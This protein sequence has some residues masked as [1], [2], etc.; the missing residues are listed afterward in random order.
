MTATRDTLFDGGGVM[1]GRMAALDWTATAMGPPAR[2]PQG[3]RALVRVMLGSRYAMWMGWGAEQTF[4]FNDAY[5]PT[6]G[7]KGDWAL[8]ARTRDVWKEIWSDIGPRIESVLATSRATWDEGLLLFLERSG[9][10]EETY[11]TFSYSPL[12]DDAGQVSGIFCVVTEETDRVIGERRLAILRDLAARLARA[13]TEAD[14]FAAAGDCLRNESRDLPFV[15]AYLFDGG[16]GVGRLVARCGISPDHPAAPATLGSAAPD[17]RWPTR[18]ALEESKADIVPDL[19]DRFPGLP[20]GPWPRPPK[21]AILLPI[22]QQGQP[23]PAGVFIAGLNPF[24]PLD[25]AYRSFI[26]LFVGQVA[27]GLANARAY[28]A[29][30]RRAEAL[31]ELDRAKTIFFSNVSHEF[32]TPLTLMLGP[33]LDT[34]SLQ[35]GALPRRAVDELTVVHRNGLRLLK[36]VN[37]LLDFSRIEAG[38]VQASFEATD[39][40]AYTAE[41]ASVFRSAIEKAGL[42]LT[43]DAPPLP[44]PAYIDHDMWEKIVLNLLSN[45]FKFTLEG[46]I[47]VS[48]REDRDKIHLI[49]RDSGGGIPAEELPRLFERFHRVEGTKGRTH[50]GTGIGLA[51]VYELAKIHGGAVT[52]ESELGHGSAFTVTI[53]AGRAHLPADRI[54]ATRSLAS[55]ALA[56]TRSSRRPCDG[57]PRATPRASARWTWKPAAGWCPPAAATA[58]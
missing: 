27:A 18:L 21:A 39:L 41:L 4:L 14:V 46:G 32:R 30:R 37:T 54:A 11:H 7:V 35:N 58:P 44:Q 6:L 43:I 15:L 40:A 3:L 38:R 31:A 1:G 10:V 5:L 51:L 36:L 55:T 29:E 57:A 49:V 24:R 47:S 22:S 56:P 8:G 28:E 19:S 25:D 12:F 9:Y 34:L 48:L 16:S 23:R 13:S 33:L 52:V 17:A 20:S 26:E 45:A 53:P 50:E 42:T 2:W